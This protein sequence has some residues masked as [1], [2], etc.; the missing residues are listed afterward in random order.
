VAR[1]GSLRAVCVIAPSSLSGEDSY[2]NLSI[3]PFIYLSIF[4]SI[5]L[6]IYLSIFRPI[7]LSIYLSMITARWF[8]IISIYPS[9]YLFI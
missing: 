1:V 7:D 6:S 4:R 5:A 8:Y 9:T 2:I 3:Y